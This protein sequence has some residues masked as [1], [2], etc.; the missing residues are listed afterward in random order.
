MVCYGMR[1]KTFSTQPKCRIF[2]NAEMRDTRVKGDYLFPGTDTAVRLRVANIWHLV[3]I[4]G[5]RYQC[6]R[7]AH[8]RLDFFFALRLSVM[9]RLLRKAGVPHPAWTKL[10]SLRPRYFRY[11]TADCTAQQVVQDVVS[12]WHVISCEEKTH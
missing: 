9:S 2:Q 12:P 11:D 6:R 3:S 1:L 7:A 4:T 10:P 8:N 5:T